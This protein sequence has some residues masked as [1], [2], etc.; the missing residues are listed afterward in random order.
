MCLCF[1]FWFRFDEDEAAAGDEASDFLVVS[2]S[3]VILHKGQS[4]QLL[5]IAWICAERLLLM[6]AGAVVVQKSSGGGGSAGHKEV[7]MNKNVADT[8]AVHK[9]FGRPLPFWPVPAPRPNARAWRGRRVP[10]VSG[11]AQHQP[12]DLA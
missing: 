4:A 10:R 2:Y 1:V 8:T 6:L 5:G 7:K 11:Q 12:A 9:P 3:P